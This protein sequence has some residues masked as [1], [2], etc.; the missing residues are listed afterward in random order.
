[1]RLVFVFL[2]LALRLVYFALF[3]KQRMLVTLYDWSNFWMLF[4]PELSEMENKL[5]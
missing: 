3:K 4:I 1:M 5:L 2:N